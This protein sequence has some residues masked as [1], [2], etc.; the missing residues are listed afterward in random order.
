MFDLEWLMQHRLSVSLERRHV[1][2]AFLRRLADPLKLWQDR[3]EVLVEVCADLR[4]AFRL[5]PIMDLGHCARVNGLPVF[6][7]EHLIG[8]SVHWLEATANSVQLPFA[9][10]GR[11]VVLRADRHGL[12]AAMVE[13][14]V[15]DIDA[16]VDIPVR[17]YDGVLLE[18]DRRLTDA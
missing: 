8:G 5:E 7:N 10:D 1:A 18:A 2:L 13:L 15:G 14:D 16:V 6:L 11:Q 9:G 3:L 17:A 12:R 4:F